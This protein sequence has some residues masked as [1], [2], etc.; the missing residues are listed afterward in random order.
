MLQANESAILS[1][2]LGEACHYGAL[3]G[4]TA[5]WDIN[6]EAVTLG[7]RRVEK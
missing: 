6:G 7:V 5:E 2:V 4:Y 3:E 1:D